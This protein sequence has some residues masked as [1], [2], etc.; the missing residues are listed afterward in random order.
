MLFVIDGRVLRPP[1][2]IGNGK[3]AKVDCVGHLSHGEYL[4]LCND[5]E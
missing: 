2:P 5:A 4:F 1:M 3:T